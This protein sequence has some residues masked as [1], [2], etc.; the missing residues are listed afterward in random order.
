MPFLLL[1][2]TL[3]LMCQHK[4]DVTLEITAAIVWKGKQ[5][6]NYESKDV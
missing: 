5:E 3:L 2:K 4:K 6:S 1:L